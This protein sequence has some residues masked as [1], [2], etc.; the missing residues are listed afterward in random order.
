LKKIVMKFGGTSVATGKNIRQVANLLA[1][2]AEQG[3]KIISVVSALDG[4]T[5]QLIMAAEEAKKG[6]HKY[7]SEFKQKLVRNHLK[8]AN[9][10][11]GNK[12]ILK[13]TEQVLRERLDE[14]EQVLKGISYVKE[15]TLKSR[16]TVHS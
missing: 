5:D 8:A 15:L 1:K 14:L 16:D 2:H 9:E 13:K 4:V 6:N 11:I 10:A 7:I 3:F 12:Q